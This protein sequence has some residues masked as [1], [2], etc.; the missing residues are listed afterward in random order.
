MTPEQIRIDLK[1]A[2]TG[3]FLEEQRKAAD[4]ARRARLDLW[5]RRQLELQKKDDLR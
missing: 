2:L 4:R 3:G 5:F 1:K